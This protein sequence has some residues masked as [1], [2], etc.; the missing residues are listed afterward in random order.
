MLGAL[1]YVPYKCKD[2][3]EEIIIEN[4]DA[5]KFLDGGSRYI[6]CVCSQP[7][8]ALSLRTEMSILRDGKKG[9]LFQEVIVTNLVVT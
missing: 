4:S 3:Q 8:T 6:L 7:R 1:G 2:A 5:V 9:P